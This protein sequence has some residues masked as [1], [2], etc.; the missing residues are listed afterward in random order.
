VKSTDDKYNWSDRT[1]PASA[2]IGLRA[3]HY[4]HLIEHKPNIGWIEVHS[5]NY[6]GKGGR[7]HYYLAKARELYPLSLH[8]VGLS[9]GSTDPLEL[10]HL[11]KLKKLIRQYDPG[12]V[13]EHLSWG[14][15]N[16]R[17]MN[18]LLP[19]PYTLESLNHLTQRISKVQ[20]F[21]EHRIL[22]ENASSYL[23]FK[24]SDIKEW[25]FIVEVATQANCGILLDI[26]NVYVNSKNH[27]F[28]PYTFI[29][30]IPVHM[31]EEIHLAGHTVNKFDDGQIL[32]DSHNQL[33][34]DDVWSLYDYAI[35]RFGQIPSL[36]EW[37]TDMP[38]LEVLVE[39]AHKANLILQ[40][41]P[42]DDS[43]HKPG[44]MGG[45]NESLAKVAV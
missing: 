32:I 21:L 5:E 30:A 15:F 42:L 2:G 12:L 18:D 43:Q 14:S 4:T 8:G 33:V 37:D 20:D 24:H 27:V 44:T 10:K 39:E 28:D 7:P 34:C 1:I 38:A 40:N 31:V 26:N 9:L 22:I 6:F 45:K 13:S 11:A 29:S 36:I 35:R 17:Y 16:G 41:N 19:M 3:E 23:E 25:D